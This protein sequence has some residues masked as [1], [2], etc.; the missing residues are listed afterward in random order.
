MRKLPRNPGLV[1]SDPGVGVEWG[2]LDGNLH[3][4]VVVWASWGRARGLPWTDTL[5]LQLYGQSI[6]RVKKFFTYL[7]LLMML[8]FNTQGMAF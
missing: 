1:L 6:P 8:S 3:R 2:G 7:L 5:G 4:S